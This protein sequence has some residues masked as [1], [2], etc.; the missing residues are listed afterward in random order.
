M[1][2]ICRAATVAASRTQ[3]QSQLR[4][5]W[6]PS[7]I[8]ETLPSISCLCAHFDDALNIGGVTAA[9]ARH[10]SNR[11]RRGLYDGKDVRSGNNVSFSMKATRRKF[12]PNVFR[13]RLYSETL[14][15]MVRFHVTTSALRSIDKAGGLDNYL[16][17]SKHVLEGEG[18][19][20]K[21]RIVQ[22]KK[23][24]ARLQQKAAEASDA[25]SSL[26]EH[27]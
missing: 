15:E 1:A 20:A 17:S 9:S 6:T 21:K 8:S 19:M 2:S 26:Q 7:S 27:Q 22:R 25:A 13:K 14:D 10:R 3:V 12:K 11:S 18:L 16:L 24:M 5:Q 4:V 23:L